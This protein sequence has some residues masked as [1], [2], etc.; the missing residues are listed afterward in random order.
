[1]VLPM[2]HWRFADGAVNPNRV[3]K[4]VMLN[5]DDIEHDPHC[6]ALRCL[7]STTFLTSR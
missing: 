1:V 3:S 4:G 2:I 7:C 5:A 6:T